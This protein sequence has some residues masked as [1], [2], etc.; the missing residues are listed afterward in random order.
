MAVDRTGAEPKAPPKAARIKGVDYLR[1]DGKVSQ[2]N[3]KR[4]QWTNRQHNL[5]NAA[6]P[7]RRKIHEIKRLYGLTKAEYLQ[8][9]ED[10]HHQCGICSVRVEPYTKLANVDHVPGTGMVYDKVGKRCVFRRSGLPSKNRGIL[11]NPCNTSLHSIEDVDFFERGRR[12]LARDW[13]GGNNTKRPWTAIDRAV[14]KA[15]LVGID[16]PVLKKKKRSRMDHLQ[17]YFRLN[18]DQYVRLFEENG[19]L[20]GVGCGAHLEPYTRNAHVDHD[21]ATH[22]VRAIVLRLPK[23]QPE[24]GEPRKTRIRRESP[25]VPPFLGG[26]GVGEG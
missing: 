8:M 15:A 10:Q 14:N 13:S 17:T 24:I 23:M 12:Y 3:G 4:W 25:R 5:F 19:Y 21:H 20:C 26:E 16:D 6:N 1:D 7:E 2:W 11:C 18:A 9:F 22:V